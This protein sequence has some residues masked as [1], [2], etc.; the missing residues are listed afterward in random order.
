[1]ADAIRKEEI[2]DRLAAIEDEI[3]GYEDEIRLLEDERYR[4]NKEYEAIEIDDPEEPEPFSLIKYP[5]FVGCNCGGCP[6]FGEKLTRP[7][8]AL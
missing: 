6:E 2:E 5:H 7:V 4:L 1:M 8:S 3:E